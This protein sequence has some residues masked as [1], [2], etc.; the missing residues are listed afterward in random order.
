MWD[1]SQEARLT[2]IG[3][4][5]E[6]LI[7][8]SK[9]LSDADTRRL[10][11]LNDEG[12][13]LL[14][15]KRNHQKAVGMMSYASPSEHGYADTNPGDDFGHY[16]T[17]TRWKS[18]GLPS[19]APQ[20]APPSLDISTEQVK[21][22]FDAAK[23]GVPYKVQLGQKDFA[24]GLR[25]KT[26]G[27]PLAESGLNNQLPAIQVPGPY[28]QY[29]KPFE[30]F[31]LLAHIPTVAMTGPSAAYLQHTANTNHAA[32][33]AE[34]AAKPSLGP[35]VIETFIKPMKV[36][37]TVEATMEILQDHE[38]FAAWL[39]V[40]LQ[41]E[42][43][44]SESLA[45][46]QQNA[47]GGP[48]GSEFNGLLATSGTLSQDATG[49]TFPDALSLAYVKIRTGSS[50]AEPDLVV[51]SPATAAAALRTKDLQ[52]RYLFE[53]MRGPGALNQQNRFDVFGVPVETSTQVPDGTAIVMS[54]AGGAAVG[55]IRMGLEIMYNPYGGTT[56]AG[57]DLWR[58]NQYS[59]RAEE[60]ISLSVP[61]PASI[62]VVSNLPIT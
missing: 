7:T 54:I 30:P 60:R 11:A 62:C 21:S 61:R 18:F 55:W 51:T 46:F 57:T 20:V 34:G 45:L 43:I 3:A 28:G 23:A 37:A 14:M 15:Q 39:P 35:T 33:V 40:M 47:S 41:Q 4:E 38:A 29:L 12:R 10:E 59:W 48:T 16:G 58:T 22:L 49:L 24:S 52:N 42:V 53:I 27:A 8:K 5:L 1:P 9:H 19:G 50:F 17:E 36:A 2:E 56:D 6:T 31:R 44:N 26:A 25:D 32:R 13:K